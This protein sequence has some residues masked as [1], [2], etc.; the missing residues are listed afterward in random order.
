MTLEEAK[1]FY[2]AYKGFSFHMDREEPVKY[3]MFRSLSLGKEV[4]QKWDEELLKEQFARMTEDPERAWVYHGDI[5]KIISRGNCDISFWA[6]RL[7]KEMGKMERLD[8]KNLMLIMENMAGRTESLKDGGVYLFCRHA[9][10]GKQMEEVMKQFIGFIDPKD[11]RSREN[12]PGW[13]DTKERFGR[14][15][16]MYRSA[17]GKWR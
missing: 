7:L 10:L 1:R 13:Y 8:A 6:E 15:V 16:R 17:L 12:E 2:F 5:L 14:A 4:L 9:K 11:G 3:N